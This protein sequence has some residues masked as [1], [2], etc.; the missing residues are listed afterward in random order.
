MQNHQDRRLAVEQPGILHIL[1]RI[2]H[3]RHVMQGD[4]GAVS[5]GNHQIS[6]F[7]G[8]GRLI[9]GVNLQPLVS[10]VEIA[11][12]TV[13]ICRSQGRPHVL[14]ADPVFEQ[15]SGLKLHTYC[16]KRGPAQLHIANA[17]DLRVLLLQDCVR[18]VIQ[19]SLGQRVRR[20]CQDHDRR[21]GGVE[22][23]VRRI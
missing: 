20:Q 21:V 13:G 23:P 15:H 8:L 12:R 2:F 1:H 22:F 5:V 17:A 6:I 3:V 4:G 10:L 19:L 9:I 18:G 16:G 11:L 7:R 14:K